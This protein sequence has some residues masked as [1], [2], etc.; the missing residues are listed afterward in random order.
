M[1]EALDPFAEFQPKLGS[2]FGLASPQ[3]I[4]HKYLKSSKT[5][6]YMWTA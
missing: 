4:T 5:S 1:I 3:Y 2:I 6:P